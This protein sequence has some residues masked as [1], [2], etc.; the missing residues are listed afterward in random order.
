[1][2][3]TSQ[4]LFACV[5]FGD[6]LQ[7][8]PT[9]GVGLALAPAR[10]WRETAEES[11]FTFVCSCSLRPVFGRFSKV[12]SAEQL[13]TNLHKQEQRKRGGHRFS[14]RP[15]HPLHDGVKSPVLKG[16]VTILQF[17]TAFREIY[18]GNFA[19]K[20]KLRLTIPL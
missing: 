6:S 8:V 4:L 20:T 11:E 3:H 18:G 2:R 13:R 10:L 17:E 1:M 5:R 15:F 19:G 12:H 16:F 14:S 7:P 9:H